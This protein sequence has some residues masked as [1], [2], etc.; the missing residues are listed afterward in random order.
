[1]AFT[2]HYFTQFEFDKFYHIYNRGIDKKPI[3]LNEDN[4]HF[5][6]RKYQ[7]YIW[8]VAETVAYCLMG[9]HFHFIIKIRSLDELAALP[10][11]PER[12]VLV[13][14]NGPEWKRD[15]TAAT[16]APD[17]TTFEKL[18]NLRGSTPTAEPADCHSV[19]Y[20]QFKKLFQSYAMA[21]NKQQNRCGTLFQTPFKRALINS[22]DYL[23]DV[24]RYVH[25]N[26]VQ[27]NMV[28]QIE[29]WHWSSYNLILQNEFT[30]L[31][32][33]TVMELFGH[34]MMFINYHSS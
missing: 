1:M 30:W 15:A 9:N 19:V 5:F 2:E 14:A 21:F 6:I 18:S 34:K 29:Q 8:P 17:L 28:L 31:R 27:H 32:Q 20:P 25:K 12:F 33:S 7:K 26:P 10:Q 3:F 24:I 13:G 11:K 16:D 4:Y 23:R 22:E